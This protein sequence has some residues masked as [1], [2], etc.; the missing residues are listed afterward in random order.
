MLDTE[1][2]SHPPERRAALITR[3][4][5]LYRLALFG[6]LSVG[7][8]LGIW[9]NLMIVGMNV[10]RRRRSNARRRRHQRCHLPIQE[11]LSNA[12]TS[13][14]MDGIQIFRPGVATKHASTELE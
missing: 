2:H 9:H 13:T 11:H 14:G 8:A 5:W 3:R 1:D 12:R 7:V 10:R 4:R 6:I